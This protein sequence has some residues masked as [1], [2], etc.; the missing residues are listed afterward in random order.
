MTFSHFPDVEQFGFQRLF[1]GLFKFENNCKILEQGIRF[2]LVFLVL[3]PYVPSTRMI[4][5]A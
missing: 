3:T 2:G 5:S 1:L 4:F